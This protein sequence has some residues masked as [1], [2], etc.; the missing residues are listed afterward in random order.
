MRKPPSTPSSTQQPSHSGITPKS[1]LQGKKDSGHKVLNTSAKSRRKLPHNASEV[2]GGEGKPSLGHPSKLS[3]GDMEDADAKAQEPGQATPTR[4]SPVAGTVPV[5]PLP[6]EMASLEESER[7]PLFSGGW[8]SQPL[9]SVDLAK[10]APTLDITDSVNTESVKAT[11]DEYSSEKE[12]VVDTLIDL[13]EDVSTSIEQT[14]VAGT[15]STGTLT[16]EHRVPSDKEVLLH[17]VDQPDE[18]GRERAGVPPEEPGKQEGD[19][20]DGG[21]LEQTSPPPGIIPPGGTVGELTS[22]V[23][24]YQQD[25]GAIGAAVA[26]TEM[27]TPS[28]GSQ[29]SV[30]EDTDIITASAPDGDVLQQVLLESGSADEQ[31]GPKGGAGQSL[32]EG[33]SPLPPELPSQEEGLS[34]VEADTSEAGQPSEKF[35]KREES[36]DEF[37]EEWPHPGVREQEAPYRENTDDVQEGLLGEDQSLHGQVLSSPEGHR[38]EQEAEFMT[39]AA[40]LAPLSSAG[41]QP[42]LETQLRITQEVC[43]ASLCMGLTVQCVSR[44]KWDQ[45]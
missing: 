44:F 1:R 5:Q 10:S 21:R 19:E 45:L 28:E 37:E 12:E 24:E 23:V 38:E 35:Q 9:V 31:Q 18:P 34:T 4:E 13:S 11:R 27:S 22:T 36:H 32:V 17:Q 33:H 7:E 16:K 40:S 39:P 25:E 26:S 20:W 15:G 2:E 42:E 8:Q 3:S 41:S 30:S 14:D 43:V 29:P 6:T